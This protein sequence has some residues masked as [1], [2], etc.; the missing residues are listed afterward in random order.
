MNTNISHRFLDRRNEVSLNQ[1]VTTCH[2]SRSC[3]TLPQITAF[4]TTM[5]LLLFYFEHLK[6]RRQCSAITDAGLVG[7]P[8]ISEVAT[9]AKIEV[10]QVNKQ[11]QHQ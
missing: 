9:I 1:P 11:A 6:D 8:S 2:M 3:T 4:R 7:N 10:T 5:S